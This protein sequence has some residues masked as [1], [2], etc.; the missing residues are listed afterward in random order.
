MYISGILYL[1]MKLTLWFILI[2]C[3]V[4]LVSSC[5]TELKFSALGG[6]K[7]KKKDNIRQIRSNGKNCYIN[8]DCDVTYD[9]WFICITWFVTDEWDLEGACII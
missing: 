1:R 5:V 7:K 2:H 8:S 3:S 6:T 9:A 4:I